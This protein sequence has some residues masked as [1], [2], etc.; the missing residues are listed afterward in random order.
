MSKKYF[1]STSKNV[2]LLFF[3]DMELIRI[4]GKDTIISAGDKERKT[5]LPIIN[6]LSKAVI[7]RLMEDKDPYELFIQ[8]P[9]VDTHTKN[10]LNKSLHELKIELP[11]PSKLNTVSFPIHTQLTEILAI[12]YRTFSFQKGLRTA[13][14][15][16][17]AL[18]K[19]HL[20]DNSKISE[21]RTKRGHNSLSTFT[22]YEGIHLPDSNELG[23]M[24]KERQVIGSEPTDLISAAWAE[25]TYAQA[26]NRPVSLCTYCGKTYRLDGKD[27]RGNYSKSNCGQES[28]KML[29]RLQREHHKRIHNGKEVREKEKKRKQTSRLKRNAYQLYMEG[30]NGRQISSELNHSEV[31]VRNWITEFT[32]LN[33]EE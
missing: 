7:G 33:K 32:Q 24:D 18:L 23:K 26:L 8:H 21:L 29:A 9:S 20:L 30:K 22:F 14:T 10:I 6:A 12:M 27:R 1:I 13:N 17:L 19:N 25:L 28:C 5:P 11:F 4:Y 2:T 3:T 16:F 15:R 31:D